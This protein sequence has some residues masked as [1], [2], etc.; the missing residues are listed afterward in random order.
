MDSECM[1]WRCTA[2]G[3]KSFTYATKEITNTLQ[4]KYQLCRNLECQQ[5]EV[6]DLSL[7]HVIDRPK[8]KPQIDEVK[9]W[10]KSLPK[11]ERAELL[12]ALSD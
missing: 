4:Q 3:E 7:S 12:E 8:E 5:R 2:C 11:E 1:G 6:L 9:Q 10:A